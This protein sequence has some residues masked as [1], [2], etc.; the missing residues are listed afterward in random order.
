[1]EGLTILTGSK[2]GKVILRWQKMLEKLRCP[3]RGTP[4]TNISIMLLAIIKS[5]REMSHLDIMCESSVGKN[6][7]KAVTR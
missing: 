6:R 7:R 3:R 2:K 1:M 4:Q 5:K